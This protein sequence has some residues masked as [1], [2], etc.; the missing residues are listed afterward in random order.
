MINIKT[1]KSHLEDLELIIFDKDGTITDS[2]FFWQEIINR[3]SKN[4]CKYFSL[5]VSYKKELEFVMGLDPISRKLRPEGPIAIKSREEVIFEIEKFF[6]ERGLNFNKKDF[7]IIFS[8]THKEFEKEAYD[9]V[10]PIHSAINFLELIPFKKVKLVLITSDS[11]ANSKIALDKLGLTQK[12]DLIIG[13]DSGLGDKK[14]GKPASYVC[15]QL[16]IPKSKTI[17]IGDSKMDY[18]MSLKAGL[19]NC[20]LVATGQIPLEELELINSLSFNSLSE[21]KIY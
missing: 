18:D 4:I 16:S 2:N 19:K 17:V 7:Y 15:E 14:S 6:K 5:P 8:E 11:K 21:L 10:K 13:H 20:I 1:N 3:R 12:F 9:F